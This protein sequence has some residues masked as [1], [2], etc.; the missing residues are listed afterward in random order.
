MGLD[1]CLALTKRVHRV[2]FP[3]VAPHPKVGLL[4]AS[5]HRDGSPTLRVCA[6][7]RRY[8]LGSTIFDES[9]TDRVAWTALSELSIRVQPKLWD[10]VEGVSRRSKATKCLHSLKFF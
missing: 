8:G 1:V 3:A 5:H 4:V 10:G 9:P 2:R 6:S 7:S